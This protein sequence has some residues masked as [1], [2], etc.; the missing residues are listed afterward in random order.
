M[1]WYTLPGSVPWLTLS[2]VIPLAGALLVALTPGEVRRVVKQLGVLSAV[3][4][5]VL[6]LVIIGGFQHGVGNLQ[7]QFGETLQ[8]IPSAGISY[9]LGVDGL[10]LFLLGL[11]ALLFLIAIVIVDPL[12][13]RLKQFILLLLI[14]EAATAGI[15]L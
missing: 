12:T 15:L 10:S 6:V 11:N 7:L 2:L 4:T 1:S 3:I 8:W 9:H 13:P 14:L 5:L